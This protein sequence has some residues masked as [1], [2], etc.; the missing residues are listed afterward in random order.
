LTEVCP[1][2]GD[3]E[4]PEQCGGGDVIGSCCG[5]GGR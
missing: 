3:V 4:L 5:A 2:G 1:V